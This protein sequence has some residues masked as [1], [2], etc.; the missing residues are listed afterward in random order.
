MR[1]RKNKLTK[2]DVGRGI[3]MAGFLSTFFLAGPLAIWDKAE[4]DLEPTV[5]LTCLTS[6]QTV[7]L[8]TLSIN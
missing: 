2:Q 1:S 5:A 6:F 4:R 3:Q 7:S 8:R